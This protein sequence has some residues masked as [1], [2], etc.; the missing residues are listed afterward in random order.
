MNRTTKWLALA[1]CVAVVCGLAGRQHFVKAAEE[2]AYS[3]PAEGGDAAS[4]LD[5][6]VE[7]LDRIVDRMAAE[8]RGPPPDRPG[9][10]GPDARDDRA[11]RDDHAEHRDHDGPS[12]EHGQRGPGRHEDRGGPGMR[13][14]GRRGPPGPWGEVPPEM[15][16]MMQRRMHETRQRMDQAREKFQELE[17]RVKK[18]EAEVERLKSA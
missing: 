14:E 16:E 6:L 17:Q 8:R 1:G 3:R 13:G 4:R 2:G 5:R 11:E 10:R 18:L 12:R 9:R 7:K 15:R